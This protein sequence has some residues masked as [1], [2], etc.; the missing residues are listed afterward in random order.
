MQGVT[1]DQTVK[2]RHMG[3]STHQVPIEV[4][5]LQGKSLA[6]RWLLEAS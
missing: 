5:T 4:G 6:I 1:P 3:A 2:A